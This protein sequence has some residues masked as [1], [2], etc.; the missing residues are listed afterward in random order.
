MAV[1]CNAIT[2]TPPLTMAKTYTYILFVLFILIA[3]CK[4]DQLHFKNVEKINSYSD[5]DRLNKVIF[6]DSSN[7]FIVGGKWYTEALILRTRD[8]GNTWDRQSFTNVGQLLNSVTQSPDGSVYCIG[9][10]GKLMQSTDTGKTWKFK[11]L[12]HY[13]FRDVAFTSPSQAIVVGGISFGSGMRIKI[14]S[15]G[16][17]ENRDSFTYQL[18]QVAMVSPTVGYTC[19]FG[20]VLKT[21]DG[22]NTWNIQN[23]ENDNFTAMDVHGDEIWICGYNG[24]IFHTVDGGNNWKRLRNGNDIT[25]VNYRLMSILFTDTKNGWAAGENG[26]VLYTDDGGH[27][28]MEYTHFTNNMLYSIAL[29]PDGRLMVVG[30]NGSIYKL[31]R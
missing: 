17:L 12:E 15:S 26:V 31:T 24:S 8:G 3:A 4:K 14:D 18:N 9:F 6:T 10:E 7:G 23:I 27:H 22:G 28:W 2:S 16:T 25:L 21:T 19:G 13:W 5:S 20:I 11:Q 30:D 29:C 1:Y